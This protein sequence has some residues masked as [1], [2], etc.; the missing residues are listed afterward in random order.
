MSVIMIGDR[1]TAQILINILVRKQWGFKVTVRNDIEFTM[2]EHIRLHNLS[3]QFVFL[4]V[5]RNYSPCI[6]HRQIFTMQK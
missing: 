2:T 6:L 4:S 5:Y 3:Y 1:I